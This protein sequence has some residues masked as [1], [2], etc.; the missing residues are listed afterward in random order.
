MLRAMAGLTTEIVDSGV[1]VVRLQRPKANTFD[2]AL[3]KSV[4]E[5]V[6]DAVARDDVR[7]LVITGDGKFFSAGLDFAALQQALMSGPE[8]G[9]GFGASMRETFLALWQCSKPTVAAV[10]GHAI[11]AGLFLALCCD[12]RYVVQG[13]AKFAVNELLFGA[14]FPP[15]AIELGRWTMGRDFAKVILGA[16][17]YDWE[18]G[19]ANNTFH[20]H[21]DSHEQ[22]LAAAIER[23][24]ALGAMPAASYAHVKTQLIAPHL[25]RVLAETPEHAAKTSAIYTSPESLATMQ[26]FL[27]GG[28]R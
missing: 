24:A 8:A 4:R 9:V 6:A 5:A 23:A 27:A 12:F 28:M 25:E 11:A 13:D 2:L 1:Y 20:D 7:A 3:M 18:A 14:G 17:H 16:Q 26:K 10:N 15:I 19:L 22:L 21:A